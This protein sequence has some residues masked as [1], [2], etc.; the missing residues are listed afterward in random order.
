MLPGN[1]MA[2]RVTGEERMGGHL[3]VSVWIELMC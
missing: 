1:H 3:H 2:R